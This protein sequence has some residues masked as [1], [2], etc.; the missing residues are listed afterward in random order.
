MEHVKGNIYAE[1]I[2]PGC[3]VGIIATSKGSVIVDTPLISR[4]AKALNEDLIERQHQ[5]VRFIVITHGHGDH[6]LGTALFGEDTLVIG[7]RRSYERMGKHKRSWVREWA[8][9]WN[10]ENQDELSEMMAARIWL[11]DVVFEDELTLKLGD[12]EIVILPLPGH[13]PEIV[14]VFVPEA[15]ALITGDALFCGHHPYMGE[16]NFQVWLESLEKMK[17]LK[18]KCIIPG[19]GPVC[20]VEAIEKQQQYME[21][22][23]EVSTT[24]NPEEGEDAIPSYVIDELLA[25]YPLHGRP[26]A[27][28]RTRILESIRVAAN[29]KF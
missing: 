15:G 20:G 9:S 24:W 19:H 1:L 26:E 4:Q 2:S 11:P 22:M 18:P 25:F 16:G 23:V 12:V 17:N 10:W 3:N 13:L 7:N 5:A 8:G 6:I 14:G 29:P 27:M 21:K 28:M